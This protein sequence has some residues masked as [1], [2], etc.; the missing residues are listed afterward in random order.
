MKLKYSRQREAIY[1]F[2]KLRKDHPTAETV[3]D[4]IRQ[5]CPNISLGTVYRNLQL[6]ESLGMLQKINVGDGV[7]HFDADV[8]D[9]YHFYCNRCKAV[10]D[11]KMDTLGQINDIA[12]R[13]F[14]GTIDSHSLIFSGTCGR[15]LSNSAAAPEEGPVDSA[16]PE[17]GAS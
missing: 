17:A 11:M 1:D 6:L 8:S 9:H 2:L 14:D 16:F 12:S 4:N 5:T 3:Y 15:C 13:N 7:E 10:I